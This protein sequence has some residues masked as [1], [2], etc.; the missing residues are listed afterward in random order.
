MISRVNAT[1]PPQSSFSRLSWSRSI[2]LAL[3]IAL[4]SL[5]APADAA[6]PRTRLSKSEQLAVKKLVAPAVKE[7]LAGLTWFGD[8]GLERHTPL[9]VPHLK[10]EDKSVRA[11]AQHTLLRMWSRSGD[12]EID[13]LFQTGVSAMHGGQLSESLDVFSE[14]I[15]RKPSFTEAWNKRATIYFLMED[16]YRSLADCDVV[17]ERVPTHFGALSGY[18]QIYLR[19]GDE[20]KSLDYFKRAYEVNPNLDGVEAT[21]RALERVVEK[22]QRSRI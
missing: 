7:R 8:N 19:L 2:A 22:K 13:K 16:F 15:R 3:A 12:G 4:A 18:G 14:I 10:D 17:V 9:V 6:T 11:L 5:A 1:T 21:I 20:E